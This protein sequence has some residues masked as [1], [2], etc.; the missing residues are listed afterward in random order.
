[1][2][3][4]D[5]NKHQSWTTFN[6]GE[7]VDSCVQRLALNLFFIDVQTGEKAVFFSTCEVY[8]LIIFLFCFL[9]FL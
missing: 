5:A 1:M 2:E 8:T 9:I 6:P 3:L 4:V 7:P